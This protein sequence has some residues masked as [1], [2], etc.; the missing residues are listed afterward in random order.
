[1][2]KITQ[3]INETHPRLSNL[4]VSNE[5]IET[6]KNT[7]KKIDVFAQHPNDYRITKFSQGILYLSVST[8]AFATQIRYSSSM[9]L[10]SLINN[11]PDV[12]FNAIQCKVSTFSTPMQNTSVYQKLKTK[13]ISEKTKTGLS[14]LSEAVDSEALKEALKRFIVS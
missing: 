9:I 14:K 1:M 5:I 2:K 6:I 10:Q 8:A 13:K 12:E 4:M 7:L 11:I 3:F